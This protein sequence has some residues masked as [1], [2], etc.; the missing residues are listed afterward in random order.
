[1]IIPGN[2]HFL[3]K[4]TGKTDNKYVQLLVLQHCCKTGSKEMLRVLPPTNQTCLATNQVVA[5]CEKL[6]QNIEG[7]STFLKQKSVHVVRF[8][9]TRQICFAA[10]DVTTVNGASP[11]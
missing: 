9:G 10:S 5:G 6:L 7:G 1:M 11:T 4:G 3:D 2:K 8:T